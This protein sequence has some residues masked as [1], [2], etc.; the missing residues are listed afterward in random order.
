MRKTITTL[1]A[2]V[3]VAGVAYAQGA[4][5]GS[6][7]KTIAQQL[8]EEATAGAGYIQQ[9]FINNVGEGLTE[10]FGSKRS[11]QMMETLTGQGLSQKDTL[12]LLNGKTT[13]SGLQDMFGASR[14]E[15]S[16]LEKILGN[17]VDNKNR[18]MFF[19][20]MVV[21]MVIDFDVD[22]D[23]DF[24]KQA[25]GAR[26]EMDSDAF[27][28]MLK[29]S[30]STNT[31]KD[32]FGFGDKADCKFMQQILNQMMQSMFFQHP[33]AESM[34][35]NRGKPLSPKDMSQF[36]QLSE[37]MAGFPGEGNTFGEGMAGG[38]P[39]DV[40]MPPCP[41]AGG[42]FESLFGEEKPEEKK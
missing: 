10:A 32:G 35:M 37:G 25:C 13:R 20:V 19:G 4:G 21:V 39:F 3:C 29:G 31:I 36:G 15:L 30:V 41:F 33:M 34:G 22:P 38:M 5:S 2:V 40:K 11:N 24:C 16:D 28:K 6:G 26:D 42:N 12:D 17:S 1:L 14:A 7:K 27:A 23:S 8:R 9:D 18:K